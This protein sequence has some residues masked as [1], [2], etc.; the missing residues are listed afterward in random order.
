MDEVDR[1]WK[2]G[3]L[4]RA[5]G[6]TIRA[7]HHYDDVGLLV[8]ARTE[9]GHRVYSR[10]D[11]ER[12]YRVLAL[13]GVGMALDDI[14]AVLDDEGV[15][16]MDTVR[17]H[18]AA[19]ERDIEQRRRLLDRLRDMLD[20]LAHSSK[21]TVDE[22]I[23]AVEAMTVV[24]AT[25]DDIVTRDRWSAAWEL[26]EPHV[27]LLRETDGDRIVP[28]WIGE[29]EARAL[30]VQRQGMTLPRP[31]GHDLMVALL[32]AVDAHVERIVIER[33]R[34]YT[35]FAT[36]TVVSGGEPHE[37]D[38]RPSDAI[39]L[40]ARAGAPI[41]IANEVIETA[42]LTAW[43]GPQ[44]AAIGGNDPPPWM[45]LGQRRSQSLE[46]T[47]SINEGSPTILRLAAAQAH[48]L[49]HDFVGSP[50]LLLGILANEEDPAAARLLEHHGVTLQATRN[51]VAE[52]LTDALQTTSPADTPSLTRSAMFAMHRASVESR[53]RGAPDI[54]PMHLLLA[55]I[56]SPGAAETLGLR[57][58]DLP[59]VRDDARSHLDT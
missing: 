25:I 44:E 55:L 45:P 47:Y 27:I 22:L 1:T 19:V 34:D 16:L 4:A 8:P 56:D 43:P 53:R 49:G 24:E 38:A 18:V 17:R 35:F 7:L 40:A 5:T 9:S 46:L 21:P 57:D 11:V 41:Q 54:A 48:D 26:H 52:T 33:L 10:D 31:L 59:A 3:E 15:S 30:V 28:I 23:G 20:A 51:A 42:G 14:G 12:L 6:L 29:P 32:D 2:V 39:N 36:V 58:I 37:I 50:H 13:R